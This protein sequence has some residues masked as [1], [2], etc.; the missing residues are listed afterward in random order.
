MQK[1]P[2]EEFFFSVFLYLINPI[3]KSGEAYTVHVY[4][5]YMYKKIICTLCTSYKAEATCG[6]SVR[7]AAS[8]HICDGDEMHASI[9][10]LIHRT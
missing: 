6:T 2:T 9:N 1:F 5:Y 10:S 4:M 3:C 8:L 7:V